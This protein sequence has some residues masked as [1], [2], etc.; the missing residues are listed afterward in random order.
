MNIIE[1]RP[2]NQNQAS[3]E[4]IEAVNSPTFNVHR[5]I[6]LLCKNA[7]NIGIHFFLCQR[8]ENFPHSELQFYIPQ[9]VQILLTI[10]TESMAL[11]DLLLKLRT[12]NPHFALLTFWQLQALLTDLSTDP[13]S[14][15]F[16]VARRVLNSLQANL[17]STDVSEIE[18]KTKMHEN[19][20]PAL[21]MSS[22]VF[23]CMALPQLAESIEPLVRSQGRRQKSYVFKLA[24]NLMKDFTRNMTLKN[25]LHNKS[26]KKKT[27]H[28]TQAAPVDIINP[29]TTK[30]DV[31]FRKSKSTEINLDFDMVDNVGQKVFEE[32]ISTSIRMPKRKTRPTDGMQR[33]STDTS[34]RTLGTS[35]PQRLRGFDAVSS[36]EE[37][38]RVSQT[39]TGQN[40]DESDEETDSESRIPM[41]TDRFI[42]SMPDLIGNKPRNSGSSYTSLAKSSGGLSRSHSQSVK[43]DA[44]RNYTNTD[45]RFKELDPS[46]IPTTVKIKMLKA[47]YFR[48]ETQ[49]AI[50]LETI[51]RSL[52]QVPTEARLSALRA[53]LSLLN[54]DLPACVDIP[55]LLPPNKKGKLHKLVLI[56]ANEAQVLN[57]AEKVPYLLLIEYLR[58]EFDFDPT[59]PENEEI[60]KKGNNHSNLIFDLN[61]ITKNRKKF[62]E[63]TIFSSTDA[64]PSKNSRHASSTPGEDTSKSNSSV[65]LLKEED[66]GDMSMI[67]VK[68]LSDAEAYRSSLVLKR[69]SNVPVLPT[70]SH[71]RTPELNFSSTMQEFINQGNNLSDSF[72]SQ[73]DDLADQMRVS[74]VMLAQLD[75]S[76]Q[77]LSE[78]TNQI[79][80]QIIASMKE[81]QDRFGYKDV[82]NLHG[83]AGERKL[84]ND[85]ITAGISSSYLG[86][87]WATK[88]ERIR[89]TSEY[90]HLENWDLCS[91]IAKTGDDLR[92]EAFACQ[93]IQAMAQI[94]TSERVD[95]WVKR[96]KILITSA[97]TGLVETIT[98]AMSVHSIKKALS[99]KMIE[100]GE[101]DANGGIATLK[102]H[103]LRMFGDPEGFK[104][105]R[106]Q[107]NFASSLAAYSIIC[108]LLQIKDRHNGNIMIDNEGHVSHIDFGFM[109]S[110]SPGSVNFEAAPFKLTYEY[111]ELLGGLDGAPYKKFVQLTKDSFKA[112]RKYAD[113]IVSMCEIMQKDN[114]QPCFN[115]GQQTSIQLRQR[116]HLEL[117]EE[118]TDAFVDNFLIGRSLG[119]IYTRLYDQFQ[120]LTQGIYS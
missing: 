35:K 38:P 75:Q 118:E 21:V 14:Y 31:M 42:S 50:A 93:L 84:E 102:D 85:L 89:K 11:E 119:N 59:T 117:T 120:L 26:H 54:R 45:S 20:A 72:K 43:H 28:I 88:K 73:T 58:D 92:Q 30:E 77:Q 98:N 51:S 97:N 105:K 19:V 15:G 4:V 86:E 1:N 109:L 57:S 74:A 18:K 96:M 5:C 82:E 106:A 17:F 70:D 29:T 95:V 52:A 40:S 61:Y 91:V 101:L 24:K 66:L 78:T 111:V 3:E 63:D 8:L 100:D 36:P 99:K 69:A 22:M 108:Y 80:A 34:I 41:K 116:F 23:S 68:N 46:K 6:E 53:E 60:I 103:Y 33:T 9:L 27:K 71:D 76:P 32:R 48:C 65:N 2:K 81:V 39:N 44:T 10:E 25:T 104:F 62:D 55:T 49:F 56:T 37:S 114:M 79:R 67:R 16:Q 83:K 94:W 12:E 107:D 112:L 7:N 64:I 110:N 90:G 115:A 87:D 113:Q 47:N 13:E